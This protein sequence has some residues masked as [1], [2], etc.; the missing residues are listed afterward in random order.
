MEFKTWLSRHDFINGISK[1]KGISA[2]S[3]QHTNIPYEIDIYVSP[4]NQDLIERVRL[5]CY[6]HAAAVF[7]INV[8]G[9]ND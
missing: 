4:N 1:I 7:K 6:N 2:V 8:R 3:L 5:E 9:K